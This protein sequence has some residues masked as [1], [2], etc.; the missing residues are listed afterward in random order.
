MA[1]FHLFITQVDSE[2][3]S[4]VYKILEKPKTNVQLLI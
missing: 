1:G 4:F 2:Q 3:F